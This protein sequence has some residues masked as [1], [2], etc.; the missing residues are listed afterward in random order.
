MDRFFDRLAKGLALLGG[1]IVVSITLVTTWSV[2]GRWLF[3]S[4]LLGDTE[5]V[6]YGMS[7][8]VACFLPLCQWRSENIIVDFFTVR[9]SRATR[10]RLDRLG[11]LMVGLMLGLV[12]WRTT[13]GA[14]DQHRY[15]TTTML[16]RWPEWLAYGLM[17][18]PIVATAVIAVYMAATG[19]GA[20][21]VA[22][23]AMPTHNPLPQDVAGGN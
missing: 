19:R 11:Y 3:N 9:A 14:I 20:S 6:E 5:V 16:M 23:T 21:S 18:V 15:G 2:L 10:D 22:G 17:A 1:A 8:V 12:G 13:L 4:P 7:M